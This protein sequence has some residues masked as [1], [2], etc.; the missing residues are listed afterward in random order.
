MDP[1]M[2]PPTCFL[3]DCTSKLQHPQ[4]CHH[5]EDSFCH[6]HVSPYCH[7]CP[8]IANTLITE[9]QSG[10]QFALWHVQSYPCSLQGCL[11]C[12]PMKLECCMCGKH[13]CS[14]HRRHG[15]IDPFLKEIQEKRMKRETNRL[16]F[17][18]AKGNVDAMVDTIIEKHRN[19]SGS[20][21]STANQI[22]LMRLKQRASGRRDIPVKD[23]AYFLLHWKPSGSRHLE[24]RA[25]YV[26]KNWSVKQMIEMAAEHCNALV[27]GDSELSL[28]SLRLFQ[29]DG[30]LLT[31]DLS[32]IVENL[33]FENI[34][35]D[36]GNVLLDD[37]SQSIP[38][39]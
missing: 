39:A 37:I 21:L 23:R 17:E 7:N 34:L 12:G 14:Y 4:Q 27:N 24:R 9:D 30:S 26:S 16:K 2:D 32:A 28:Q 5:C 18:I 38:F 35:T 29:M 10:N 22:Q 36:G 8:S 13:Y 31:E 20:K 19:L 15:C 3:E 25:L 6:Q 33:I 1:L 11:N